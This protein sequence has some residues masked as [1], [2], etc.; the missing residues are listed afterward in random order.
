MG[1]LI[2]RESLVLFSLRQ[3]LSDMEPGN[4]R[5]LLLYLKVFFPQVELILR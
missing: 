2:Y 1:G 5:E 4:K 3:R